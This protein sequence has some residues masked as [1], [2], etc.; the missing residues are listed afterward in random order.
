MRE[1]QYWTLPNEHHDDNFDT[2][3]YRVRELLENA[4]RDRCV[5][6][7]SAMLSG[8]LDS[9]AVAG[10]VQAERRAKGL[11]SLST[12]CISF[13]SDRTH[14]VQSELRPDL[15]APFAAKAAES[16]GTAHIPLTITAN[17]LRDA[18][19]DIRRARAMP[20]WGQFDA[21]MFVLFRAMRKLSRVGLTGET[22]DEL[23]GGYPYLFDE[24]LI[25]RNTF[26]WLGDSEKLSDFLSP[27]AMER[28]RPDRAEQERYDEIISRTPRMPNEDK[29]ESRIREILFLGMAGPLSVVIDRKE[30]MSSAAGFDVRM[31]Y[32]D[33]KLV[34]YVWSTPWAFKSKGGVKG[35]LKAAVSDIVPRIA[36][37][38]KKS[39]YPHIRCPEYDAQLIADA[40]D[41]VNDTTS[42]VGQ[43]FDRSRFGD[44]LKRV[45][46]DQ[47]GTKLPG[48]ASAAGLLTQV[49]EFDRWLRDY[50][51]VLD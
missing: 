43:L 14:F 41:I 44:F 28:A 22:A 38:R 23:F 15:D 47:V 25:N 3:V 27:D 39:A 48:G 29:K 37:E 9:T 13:D 6:A 1:Q 4:V 19:P 26:P 16:L 18:L 5:G 12:F 36:L 50:T 40:R 32:C 11:E 51:I 8:G 34:E 17:E 35:L 10:L 42:V 46:S 7:D 30:R 33:H 45:E 24:T 31:P 2:S 49:V 21:S 20:A